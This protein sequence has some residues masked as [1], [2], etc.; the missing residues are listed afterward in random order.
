MK[1]ATVNGGAASSIGASVGDEDYQ[2]YVPLKVR[3]AQAEAARR[4]RMR[5]G[6]VSSKEEDGAGNGSRVD[7]DDGGVQH[8]DG[9]GGHGPTASGLTS[10]AAGH[11]AP[12]SL[13]EQARLA[14]ASAPQQTDEEKRKALEADIL[15]QVMQ[16]QKHALSTAKE[17]AEGIRYTEALQ[18][19]WRPPYH[20]RQYSEEK[21]TQL[22]KKWHIL[23]DGENIPPPIK[24]FADMRF[25]DAILEGLK[26]KGIERPT[27]IQVQGLPVALSGRDMIGIAFTGSGKTIA[28]CLPLVMF[29]LQEEL[30]MPL[31]RGEGPVGIILAPSRELARQHSE[32]CAHFADYIHRRGGPEL[33]TMLAIG[34]EDL[35]TQLAPVNK[36]E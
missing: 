28:F 36:G 10:D 13:L 24:S 16:V 2:E 31:T 30:R 25:P 22:R 5:G 9:G 12:V 21:C 18:T 8:V 14:A 29:S 23:V 1:R 19:D 17:H 35:K 4:K 20:I 27:P 7:A 6:S 34:G 26:A 32:N 15:A 3:K 33:R 11:R